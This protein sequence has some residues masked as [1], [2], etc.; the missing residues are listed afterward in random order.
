MTPSVTTIRPISG[1]RTD[2]FLCRY[3]KE[4][5][6]Q[7]EKA[8]TATKRAAEDGPATSADGQPAKRPRGRPKGSKTNKGKAKEAAPTGTPAPGTAPSVAAS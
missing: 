1:M 3:L 5:R 4:L 8:S 6:L 7:T 2:V